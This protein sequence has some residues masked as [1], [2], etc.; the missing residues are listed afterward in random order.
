MIKKD[1]KNIELILSNARA[2]LDMEGL[3][4]T[5]R[6][7]EIIRKYFNEEYTEKEI[8]EIIKNS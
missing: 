6:E 7:V 4:V 2:S 1:Y 3:T 8:L 5:E